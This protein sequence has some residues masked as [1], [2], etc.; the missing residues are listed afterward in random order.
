MSKANGKIQPIFNPYQYRVTSA[1]FRE[2]GDNAERVKRFKFETSKRFSMD[3][4]RG[5]RRGVIKL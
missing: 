3:K 5:V 1:T 4:A 2:K